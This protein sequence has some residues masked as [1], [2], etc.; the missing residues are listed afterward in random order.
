[1]FIKEGNVVRQTALREP[2]KTEKAWVDQAFQD[3][4]KTLALLHWPSTAAREVDPHPDR[5]QLTYADD[6]LV[7]SVFTPEGDHLLPF[8]V[9]LGP[10]I[11]V[12][13]H[14]QPIQVIAD[15]A[16]ELPT[17]PE[18]LESAHYLL[19]DLLERLADSYLERMD[20]YE[21]AFDELEEAILDGQDR[22][23]EVF[24]LRRELHHMRGILA[25]MRRMAARLSRR[26]FR[27]SADGTPDANIFVDVYDGFYHVMDNIDSLRDNLTGLVDLQLNQRSTRMNE[28]MKFLTIF[29]TIFLPLSFIT[30]FLG[31]NLKSMPELAIPYGQE[32]T[33]LLMLLLAG[34]M[35][36]IF[37]RRG[38]M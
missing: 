8:S 24:R 34:T 16:K 29:S 21:E 1:M 22:A 23:R 15:L 27:D 26:D 32:M 28:I 5:A 4:E 19:Y 12:T 17:K 25:D 2:S 33:L 30:G 18:L 13:L 3:L 36:Y 9:I 37:K 35:L 6:L 11:M 38:W 14:D 10:G 7:L 31:M 20:A